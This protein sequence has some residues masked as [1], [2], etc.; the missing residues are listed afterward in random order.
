M[1]ELPSTLDLG[2]VDL[3]NQRVFLR[4]DL[5]APLSPQGEVQDDIRIKSA[6]PTIRALR[7]AGARI[8]IGS[9]FG[10]YRGG[11]GS[12]SEGKKAPSIEP[13]AAKLSELLEMEVLLPDGCTGESVK[14]VIT[15][16]RDGQVCVLENLAQESDLGS[17]RE[18]F[19]R[20]LLPQFDMYVGDSLRALTKPSASASILPRLMETRTAGL[21]L[22]AELSAALR[23]RSFSDQPRLLIWGGKSL[24]EHV[25]LLHRLL[26]EEGRVF[27]V[28][29][30]ANTM[31]RARGGQVGKS[32]VEESYLAGART[33]DEQL[34]RRLMLP[35]DFI[36]G[37]NLRQST[38][39]RVPA[40]EIPGH[41]MALDLGPETAQ[42]LE[43]EIAQ[44]G[45]VL[46]CG[47]AGL[48]KEEPFS[49]GTRALVEALEKARAFTMI[50]GDDTVSAARAVRPDCDDRIDHVATGGEATLSL[51][52]ESKL[53][54][55]EAL[56]SAPS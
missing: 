14:K 45:L 49:H 40:Q 56:R 2:D 18:T 41:L 16:L 50:A 6:L 26:G 31:L 1:S 53:V 44:A 48:A 17:G 33:L 9:R 27:L 42:A 20:Q 47:A 7:A 37:E 3:E 15:T 30:A 13:A 55:L 29:V 32:K 8:I 43:A 24:S 28:G 11:L 46:W 23:L 10:E 35:T 38:G 22:K 4:T 12:L 39:V 25:P 36:A 5:D 54:G 52:A 34:G 19:A 21:A 51:Y